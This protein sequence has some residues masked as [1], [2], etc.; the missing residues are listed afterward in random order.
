MDD[1][2]CTTLHRRRR[3]LLSARGTEGRC[4]FVGASCD[5]GGGEDGDVAPR[6]DLQRM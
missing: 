1:Y 6:V 2:R 3:R 5:R 4:V